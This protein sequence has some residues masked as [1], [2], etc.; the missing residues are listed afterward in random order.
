M[1]R[2]FPIILLLMVVSCKSTYPNEKKLSY[3]AE[4]KVGDDWEKRKAT[5]GPPDRKGEGFASYFSKG[6]VV[7]TNTEGTLVT[8][9]SFT[10]FRGGIHFTGEIYGV[11]IGDTYPKVVRL[12]GEPMPGGEKSED[13]YQKVW[14]FKKAEIAIE[15]W[16]IGGNDP[17]IG[18]KYEVDTVKKIQVTSSK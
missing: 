3:T 9:L 8:S 18:G 11:K 12:W 14:K 17:D 1:N 15:F 2:I 4:V 5:M 10:W 13:V 7:Y 6:I 16:A